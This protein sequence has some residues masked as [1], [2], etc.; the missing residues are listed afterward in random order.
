M[1]LLPGFLEHIQ[2]RTAPV[3]P[4]LVGANHQGVLWQ[5]IPGRFLL[6]ISQVARY[7]VEAGHSITIET[8]PRAL[9]TDV[10]RFWRMTPLAALVYQRG[11]LA[12]HAA[13][14][15][16]PDRHDKTGGVVLL[17]GNSG[18]GKSTLLAALLQRGWRLLADDLVVVDLNEDNHPIIFPTYP[19]IWLWPETITKLEMSSSSSISDNNKEGREMISCPAQFISTPQPLR[20]IYWLSVHNGDVIDCSELDGTARFAACAT[21][22]YNTQIADA[23]L[24]RDCFFSRATALAKSVTFRRLRRPRGR[25]SVADM[26]DMAEQHCS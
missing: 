11:L 10:D 14:V 18:A 3:S 2:I 13:A 26:A 20:A 4:K 16:P 12:F 21:L 8:A 22:S 17:A 25:W 9:S 19:E 7:L 15:V 1:I 23:L 6:N 24:D 5:A